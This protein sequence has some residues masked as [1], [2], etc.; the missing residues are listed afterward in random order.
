[1]FNDKISTP[2]TGHRL[3]PGAKIVLLLAV[4]LSVFR[5]PHGR[6]PRLDSCPGIAKALIPSKAALPDLKEA[7][8]Q[9]RASAVPRSNYGVSE[10][11]VDSHRNMGLECPD[12]LITPMAPT[13]QFDGEAWRKREVNPS[14]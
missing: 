11:A 1:M 4:G 13:A 10:S 5:I 14:G 12:E 7:W 8:W 9:R 3:K 2:P 6:E